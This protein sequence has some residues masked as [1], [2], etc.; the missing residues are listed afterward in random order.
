MKTVPGGEVKNSN[1]NISPVDKMV[2]AAN[3][4]SEKTTKKQDSF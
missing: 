4:G 1:P 2:M 3:S